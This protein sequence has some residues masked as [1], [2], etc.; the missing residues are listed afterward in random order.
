MTA[1]ISANLIA[2]NEERNIARCLQSLAWADEII[3]IDSGSSDA[4]VEI[5]RRFTDWVHVVPFDDYASQRNRALAVSTGDWVFSIDCDEWVPDEL[6][7]EVRRAVAGVGPDCGGYW[8]PIRSRIFG[9]RFRH[10]GTQS[11]RKM[12]LFRR[13]NAR[14]SGPVHETVELHGRTAVLRHAIEHESTPDLDTYL[15]K[16]IRYSS[17]EAEGIARSG[18]SRAYARGWFAPFWKFARLYFGKLG[19]LDGPEGFRFCMLSGLQE[20]VVNQKLLERTR[21]GRS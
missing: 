17:L 19:F 11:E 18:R 10:S 15:R 5:A 20:W 21:T 14:W 13:E 2:L 16:L 1:K 4:T 6:A 7:I 9:R 3:V 8:V 12:R